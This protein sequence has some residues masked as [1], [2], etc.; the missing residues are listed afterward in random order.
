MLKPKEH[1]FLI[2]CD[3]ESE[4]GKKTIAIA[5]ARQTT[6]NIQNLSLNEPSTTWISLIL[7]ELGKN[8][9]DIMNKAHPYYQEHLRGHDYDDEGW[10]NILKKNP[11]LFRCPIIHFNNK[12]YMIETPTDLFK[13]E[14]QVAADGHKLA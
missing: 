6:V 10:L 3:P 11:F 2:F 12:S 14:K 4:L 9:K 8:A 7:N 13:I 1:D 5:K